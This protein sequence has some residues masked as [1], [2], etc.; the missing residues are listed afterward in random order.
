MNGGTLNLNGSLSGPGRFTIYT[1]VFNVNAGAT[2]TMNGGNQF[3]MAN[4]NGQNAVVNDFG[5]IISRRPAAADFADCPGVFR[6][7]RQITS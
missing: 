4:G 3:T 7:G 5:T 2:F 1:A 6:N